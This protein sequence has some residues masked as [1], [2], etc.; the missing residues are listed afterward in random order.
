[1]YPLVVYWY[2]FSEYNDFKR[3][4]VDYRIKQKMKLARLTKVL[5]GPLCIFEHGG[6]FIN[7]PL[8]QL[9]YLRTRK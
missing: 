7:H 9:W 6:T 8:V 5:T 1:M 2:L 3:P 4:K